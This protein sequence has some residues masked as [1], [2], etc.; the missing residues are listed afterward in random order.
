[1]RC[2]L[3]LADAKSAAM[4]RAARERRENRRRLRHCYGLQ[5]PI[6]TAPRMHASAGWEG[7]SEVKSE[8]RIPRALCSSG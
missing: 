2:S 6:A 8:V 3:K 5:T 7:G 1:M 4:Q